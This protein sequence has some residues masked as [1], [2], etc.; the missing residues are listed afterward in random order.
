MFIPEL[1]EDKPELKEVH[2][3]VLQNVVDRLDKA[4]QAFF[5]DIKLEKSLDFHDPASI[6]QQV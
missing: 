4:F 3:Q 2:S 5:V 1:K 6:Q